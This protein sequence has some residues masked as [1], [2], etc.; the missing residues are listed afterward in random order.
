MLV[1]VSCYIL[2]V[3]YPLGLSLDCLA[4]FLDGI[5]LRLGAIN[6]TILYTHWRTL[7]WVHH[8]KSPF[9]HQTLTMSEGV[10]GKNKIRCE[11]MERKRMNKL[12]WGGSVKRKNKIRCEGVERKR[13]D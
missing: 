3:Q 7:V 10:E 4:L 13:I 12:Q 2:G 1:F 11:G 5:F 6:C 8:K 9:P